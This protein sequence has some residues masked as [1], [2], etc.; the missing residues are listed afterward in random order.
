MDLLFLSAKPILLHIELRA[1]RGVKLLLVIHALAHSKFR[2]FSE[3][4]FLRHLPNALCGFAEL[5]AKRVV[6]CRQGRRNR[7]RRGDLR[8]S[9]T[10]YFKA[11]FECRHLSG[12]LLPLGATAVTL[13]LYALNLPFEICQTGS[14]PK[15]QIRGPLLI[16]R[17]ALL[18]FV[19][20]LPKR[21]QFL[22]LLLPRLNFFGK[23]RGEVLTLT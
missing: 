13:A 17:R 19:G 14:G 7:S 1:N 9:A 20:S 23:T 4:E 6:G 16:P 3:L 8:G 12:Q 21:R 5:G 15:R 22:G 10:G 11:C 2:F 18:R